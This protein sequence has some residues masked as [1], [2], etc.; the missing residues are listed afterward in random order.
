MA[1]GTGLIGGAARY[2][3]PSVPN[4]PTFQADP[5]K[6]ASFDRSALANQAIAQGNTAGANQMA[7][8]KARLAATGGGRSSAANTQQM[9]IA[10]QLG[11]GAMNIQNQNALQGWQDKLAQMA[12]ENNF[13]LNNYGLQQQ[14][15]KTSAGLAEGERENRRN[16][17][18][19]AF[20]PLGGIANLFGGQ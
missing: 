3:T 2:G 17:V 1:G 20:G 6:Y 4:T 16:A 11:Q 19:S 8:A 18:N 13:N 12:N 10:G 9:D 15:Y 7:L 14:Q 5:S